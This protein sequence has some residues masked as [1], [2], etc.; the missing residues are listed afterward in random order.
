MTVW[1]VLKDMESV[2]LKGS[3]ESLVALYIFYIHW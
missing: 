1:C 3:L 2:Q